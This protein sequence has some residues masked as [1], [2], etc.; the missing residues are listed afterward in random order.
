MRII[1]NEFYLMPLLV[2]NTRRLREKQEL[3]YLRRVIAG[4]EES[5]GG[6]LPPI[7]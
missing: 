3:I 2:K 7:S 5:I 4:A 1:L 6:D